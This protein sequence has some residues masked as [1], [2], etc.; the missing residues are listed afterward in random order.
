MSENKYEGFTLGL[1]LVDAIPVVLFGASCILIGLLFK[2]PLF[3]IGAALS[4]LAGFFKVLWKIVLAVTGKDV[5]WMNK[6]FRYLMIGGWVLIIIS[7]IIGWKKIDPA[8]IGAAIIGLPQLIFFILGVL[9]MMAMG[10]LGKKLD[11]TKASNNWVEQ[12]VNGFAQLM[13]FLGLLCIL[14]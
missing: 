9:G 11:P 6:Q 14:L 5:K 2:S 8:A 4:F 3:L 13:I 7:V 1:A 12:C 10:V